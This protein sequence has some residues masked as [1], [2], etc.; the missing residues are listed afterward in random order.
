MSVY[1]PIPQGL[2]VLAR[3]NDEQY[4]TLREAV[5]GPLAFDRSLSRVQQ[6]TQ[7]LQPGLNV[8]DVWSLI[9]SLRFL[10]DHS[11]DWQEDGR[12]V[13]DALWDFLDFTGLNQKLGDSKSAPAYQRLLELISP[14]RSFEERKKLRWLRTG[15]LPNAVSFSSFVDVRPNFSTDRGPIDQFLPIVIFR[16]NADTE[17]DDSAVFQLTPEAVADLRKA[18]DDIE[19]KLS[20]LKSDKGFGDR[21]L[22]SSILDQDDEDE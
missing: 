4:K 7:Q 19:K 1:P 18:V 11:R 21:L 6:L 12:E 14:N 5:S 9:I 16:V 2:D 10:Y 17:S 13:A 3:L 15:I 22:T 20:V 8:R